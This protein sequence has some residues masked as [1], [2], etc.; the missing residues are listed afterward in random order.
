MLPRLWYCILFILNTY[1]PPLS[2]NISEIRTSLL[3]NNVF[4]SPLAI[5]SHVM[6]LKSITRE[7]WEKIWTIDFPSVWHCVVSVCSEAASL[8][9]WWK[10]GF[11]VE[12]G[13]SS[14]GSLSTGVG[15][16]L[17]G[18]QGGARCSWGFDNL[19]D[20][21]EP[22]KREVQASISTSPDGT[23][24]LPTQTSFNMGQPIWKIS[25]SSKVK[26]CCDIHS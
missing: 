6:S 14:L 8:W 19:P 11:Q 12:R 13:R 21:G 24:P 3:M 22:G 9:W 5:S 23:L 25:T 26:H 18:C 4:K 15:R 7:V 16:R 20:L 2:F 17:R 1:L 10:E